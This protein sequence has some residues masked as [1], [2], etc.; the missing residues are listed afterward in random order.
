MIFIGQYEE[1]Y[2]G[3][4]YPSMRNFFSDS[5][6]EGQ[7]KI[8]YYLKHGKRDMIS[9]KVPR[10]VFTGEVILMPLIRMNDGEFSWFMPLAYYV[11]H[12]NLRLPKEF[13]ERILRHR[14]YK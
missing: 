9:D 8:I 6:Y 1:L 3:N 12:Y 11:E 14:F 7:G 4:G 5:P 2:P 13:E 10:D